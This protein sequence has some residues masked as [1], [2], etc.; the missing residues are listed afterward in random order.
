[1]APRLKLTI[2]LVVLLCGLFVWAYLPPHPPHRY[3]PPQSPSPEQR[4][5]ARLS[6]KMESARWTAVAVERRGNLLAE[7]RRQGLL[8]GDSVSL[9]VDPEY[10]DN[11]RRTFEV[12]L[13]RPRQVLNGAELRGPIVIAVVLDTMPDD[14]RMRRRNP[15]GALVTH[16]LPEATDG[17]ACFSVVDIGV[18]QARMIRAGRFSPLEMRQWASPAQ[19]LGVCAYYQRFG[20]PGGEAQPLT[21]GMRSPQTHVWWWSHRTPT[22]EVSG[23]AAGDLETCRM[24]VLGEGA[25]QEDPK[26]S[27]RRAYISR[28]M[29]DGVV[30]LEPY[31]AVRHP[32]GWSSPA[33]LGDMLGDI[34]DEAFAR[35]WSSEL[36]VD[37]AFAAATGE[38]LEEWTVRWAQAQIGV[39]ER[40]P[41][42][43]FSAAA[44]G[45][46]LA[47]VLVGGGAL[48]TARRQV[49]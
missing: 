21:P 36:P 46:L 42:V 44:L 30:P 15:W 24:A 8:L 47:G 40:G 12:V 20:P 23:C 11:V 49:H 9:L 34:G 6:V 37:S 18:Y 27:G 4:A 39:K 13:E 29:P 25:F 2:A 1:M 10:P 31:W 41:F 17:T 19:I 48:L 45:L 16:F 26:L 3:V 5:V 22:I 33:Y 7:A 14:P 28:I 35:F 32:M 43:P 38:S